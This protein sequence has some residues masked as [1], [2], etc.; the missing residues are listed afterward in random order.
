MLTTLLTIPHLWDEIHMNLTALCG[1]HFQ[2]VGP[3]L[4][5]PN[6]CVS[7]RELKKECF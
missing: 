2:S 7:V 1:T 3:T 5:S 4:I 6:N